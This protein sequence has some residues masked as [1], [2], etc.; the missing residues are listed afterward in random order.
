LP[1]SRAPLVTLA[2]L[3]FLTNWNEF[4]WPI[5]V[6]FNP[7][8]L[9]LPPGLAILQGAYTTNYAV[10]MAGGVIASIPIL[11]VFIFLQRYIIQGVARSGV[12]G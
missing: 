4:L 12:K 10:I 5:F 2:V 6:L 9:T 8:S 11:I 3:S 7:Q 1:L